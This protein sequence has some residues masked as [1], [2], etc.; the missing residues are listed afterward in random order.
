MSEWKGVLLPNERVL[1]LETLKRFLIE[2]CEPELA[3]KLIAWI[4]SKEAK[5]EIERELFVHSNDVAVDSEKIFNKILSKIDQTEVADESPLEIRSIEKASAGKKIRYWAA[6]AASITL[7][8][9]VTFAWINNNGS[10]PEA[11]T[12]DPDVTVTKSTD[13]GQKLMVRLPDGSHLKLNAGSSISYGPMQAGT[14]EVEL[15][16]EA[17]FDVARDESRP[18]IVKVNNL[19]VRVL[20][21]SFNIDGRSIDNSGIVAVKSGKVEV[22]DMASDQHVLLEK[23]EYVE[24]QQGKKVLAE[25]IKNREL[26]FGW[27]ENKLVFENADLE[28]T[29]NRISDWFGYQIQSE[30]DLKALDNLTGVY[31]NPTL[32]EVLESL[33][34]SYKF[35]YEIKDKMILIK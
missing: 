4:Y 3:H 29:M 12:I 10:T 7:L 35:E 15:K 17:F 2:K 1:N 24:V 14:R 20:G 6:I 27:T 32:K 31:E 8:M 21:T 23:D 19:Q 22:R 34:Y 11:V 5:E 30:I 26:L 16:G 9:V 18:F 13:I 25:K 28:E 33:S